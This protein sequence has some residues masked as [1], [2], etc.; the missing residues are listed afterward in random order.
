MSKLFLCRVVCRVHVGLVAYFRTYY[1]GYV[2]YVGFF[3]P[4]AAI[5]RVRVCVRV[6]V[7]VRNTGKLA[8]TLHTLHLGSKTLHEPYINPTYLGTNPTWGGFFGLA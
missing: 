6:P 5:V 8:K 4:W 2:G 7:R 1:V 3:G